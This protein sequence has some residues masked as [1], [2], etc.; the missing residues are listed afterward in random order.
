MTQVTNYDVP[1]P[2][3]EHGTL[4]QIKMLVDERLQILRTRHQ[5]PW[6]NGLDRPRE[7]DQELRQLWQRRR[8]EL[9]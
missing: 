3:A 1:P 5:G 2:D 9:M 7:I 8:T 6:L 4:A